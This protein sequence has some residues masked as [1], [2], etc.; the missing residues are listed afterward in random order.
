MENSTNSIEDLFLENLL[1]DR[2]YSSFNNDVHYG[3]HLNYNNS[4]NPFSPLSSVNNDGMYLKTKNGSTPS[5]LPCFLPDEQRNTLAILDNW[6][7]MS[8]STF[9]RYSSITNMSILQETIENQNVLM[10]QMC[11]TIFEMIDVAMFVRQQPKA[12]NRIRYDCEGIRFLPDSRYHPLAI[13]VQNLQRI[14][15]AKNQT[16]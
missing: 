6:Q 10:Y 12:N 2:Y 1:P 11:P 9:D 13:H 15:L 4:I 3:D 8:N 5:E 16:L 7:M 14:A